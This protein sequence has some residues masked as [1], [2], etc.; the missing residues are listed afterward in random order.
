MLLDPAVLF[1]LWQVKMSALKKL[2]SIHQQHTE[3]TD[4]LEYN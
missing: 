4:I 2:Y 1:L 3:N